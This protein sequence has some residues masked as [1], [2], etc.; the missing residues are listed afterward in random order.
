MSLSAPWR[1]SPW[2]W[3]ARR[4]AARCRSWSA[5]AS[6]WWWRCPPPRPPPHGCWC[7][8]WVTNIFECH[9][10]FWVSQIFRSGRETNIFLNVR[11]INTNMFWMCHNLKH[12]IQ[13]FLMCLW[14]L[15]IF[16]IVTN[17]FALLPH[18]LFALNCSTNL[19]SAAAAA[20]TAARRPRPRWGLRWPANFSVKIVLTSATVTGNFLVVIN[21]HSFQA[22]KKYMS[23]PSPKLGFIDYT[24]R[25]GPVTWPWKY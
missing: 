16:V 25:Y 22:R 24:A 8:T 2:S 19:H 18:W 5:R 11:R 20:Q 9:K 15:N 12:N 6:R 21:Q 14:R 1:G 17:I 13:R 7:P 23:L 10:Y 4:A 3:R